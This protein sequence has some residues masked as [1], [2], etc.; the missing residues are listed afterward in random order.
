MRS[1]LILCALATAAHAFPTGI[2]FD[3]DPLTSD[4]GG[5]IAFTGA[6]RFAGHTCAVC[7]TN[8]P[9]TIGLRLE[10]DHPELFTDGW[11]ANMQYQMRVV[12]LNEHADAQNASLGDNCGFNART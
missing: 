9:G 6:T 2:Q 10:A 3:G 1:L 12:M 4:G 11:V 5:G 8:A 7:H